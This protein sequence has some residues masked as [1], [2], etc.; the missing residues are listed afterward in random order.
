MQGF[1][2]RYFLGGV[3]LLGLLIGA[4][5]AQVGDEIVVEATKVFVTNDAAHPVPV[6]ATA[7]LPEGFHDIVRL[8]FQGG[9]TGNWTYVDGTTRV[10]DQ[11]S[12]NGRVAAGGNHEPFLRVI[13]RVN[14]PR[15]G[16]YA[17]HVVPLQSAGPT[18]NG[19]AFYGATTP[20]HLV[21]NPGMGIM[22]L[23]D[24]RVI[25]GNDTR[26]G[27]ANVDVSFSGTTLR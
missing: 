12:V 18:T 15:T 9:G 7:A 3:M 25:R 21:L 27:L 2:N 6:A 11:V 10:I 24:A 13:L 23:A 16:R 4:A 1:K 19:L 20:M 8:S 17:D 26:D 22:V 5:Q 14:D